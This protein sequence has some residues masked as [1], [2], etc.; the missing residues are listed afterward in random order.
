LRYTSRLDIRNS[1]SKHTT[2]EVAH[3]DRVLT[4]SANVHLSSPLASNWRFLMCRSQT[5][6]TTMCSSNTGHIRAVRKHGM[7]SSQRDPLPSIE[8]PCA[9]LL[10]VALGLYRYCTPTRTSLQSGRFPVHVNTGLGSPCSDNTG[11][12]QNMTGFAEKLQQAVRLMLRYQ[13][14]QYLLAK[15]VLPISPCF[16]LPTISRQSSLINRPNTC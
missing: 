8:Q 5:P 10:V 11:I 12:S 15:F 1:V 14:R 2:F 6:A 16:T 7:H 4:L 9:A 13:R 3:D